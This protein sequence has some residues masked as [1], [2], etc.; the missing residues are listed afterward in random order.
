MKKNIS[1]HL[2]EKYINGQ[3]SEEEVEAV[4][5][6]YNSFE[7]E[8]DYVS[9]L[10]VT[11]TQDLESDLY[12][13]IA[14]EIDQSQT[15]TQL[16]RRFSVSALLL[17]TAGAAAVLL[18]AFSLFI[19]KTRDQVL[20]PE[21]IA[22]ILKQQIS[23]T[24][25]T[26][27]IYKT[28]LPDSSSVWLSPGAKISYPK[29][30]EGQ[31]RQVTMTGECFFEVT[32]NP[33]KPFV[34]NSNAII[35]KVLGTSFRVRDTKGSNY[36]EVSV[37]TGKVSVSISNPNENN[38]PQKDSE[39]MVYPHQKI[40]YVRDQLKLKSQKETKKSSVNIWHRINL[41]FENV[42]LK[43]IVP[44]LNAKYSTKIKVGDDELNSYM[45]TAD[46]EGFNLPEILEALKKSLNIN[47][48]INNDDIT[49]LK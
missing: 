10:S 49:I 38:L 22:A 35:T 25:T 34:I 28:I 13:R 20:P 45:L 18:I 9:Q 24:N 15:V 17:Y 31:T 29:V 44:I 11:E 4:K 2:L 41:S 39:I 14:A 47:Y 1:T 37:V 21:N 5:A 23:I 27:A 30:F 43:A 3:C 42:P 32:K 12:Q 33:E 7:V 19:L 8:N 48:E 36:A 46:F 6:W 16:P 26:R 40:T